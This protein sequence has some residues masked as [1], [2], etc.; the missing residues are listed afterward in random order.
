MTPQNEVLGDC[1]GFGYLLST[2]MLRAFNSDLNSETFV[3]RHFTHLLPGV[4][5]ACWVPLLNLTHKENFYTAECTHA[6]SSKNFRLTMQLPLFH[7]HTIFP[8]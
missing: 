7:L 6:L 5:R 4:R 3:D 2:M 1:T 8:G